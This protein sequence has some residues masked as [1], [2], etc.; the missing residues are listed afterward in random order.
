MLLIDILHNKVKSLQEF[1][2]SLT[3][4]KTGG[5]I[6]K[7]PPLYHFASLNTGEIKSS[8]ASLFRNNVEELLHGCLVVGY[9]EGGIYYLCLGK[10]FKD[11]REAKLCGY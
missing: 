1:N 7:F 9:I 10:Y 2:F 3:G 4:E 11:Q 5:Y 8:I 6:H